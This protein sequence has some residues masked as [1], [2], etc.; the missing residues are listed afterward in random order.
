MSQILTGILGLVCGVVSGIVIG[1]G[2]SGMAFDE[3]IAQGGFYS[4]GVRYVI[5]K[6]E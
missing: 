1:I 5:T 2:A 4:D 3:R 6:A